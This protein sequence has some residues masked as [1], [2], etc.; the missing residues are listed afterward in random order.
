M[1]HIGQWWMRNAYLTGLLAAML[2]S[3]A[4]AVTLVYW[5]GPFLT[6]PTSR[7]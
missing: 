7:P 2:G 4:A 5:L 6:A 1:A 3:F